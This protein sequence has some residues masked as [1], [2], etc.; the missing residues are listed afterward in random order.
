MQ[1]NED[2]HSQTVSF[3]KK[4]TSK[5][6]RY[7]A[8]LD[9]IYEQDGVSFFQSCCDLCFWQNGVLVDRK[10][11]SLSNDH[12]DVELQTTGDGKTVVALQ[13]VHMNVG[14]LVFSA[15]W[16][17]I[18]YMG[19]S[20]FIHLMLGSTSG[21][22]TVPIFTLLFNGFVVPAGLAMLWTGYKRHSAFIENGLEKLLVALQRFPAEINLKKEDYSAML[23]ALPVT[24]RGPGVFKSYAACVADV[25]IQSDTPMHKIGCESEG[26]LFR[27]SEWDVD[28]TYVPR[29]KDTLLLFRAM[30]DYP[31]GYLAGVFIA[32]WISWLY[33]LGYKFVINFGAG[34]VINNLAVSGFFAAFLL[35]LIT[36]FGIL[37]FQKA[38]NDRVVKQ[39][40]S[41]FKGQLESNEQGIF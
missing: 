19:I 20:F 8:T 3:T 29:N 40:M 13:S 22:S 26:F 37:F 35:M 39:A 38:R 14:Y 16:F 12:I 25:C 4:L 2:S 21:T 9:R 17:P 11:R 36:G 32:L 27:D 33:F 5:G 23:D 30:P 28:V 34:T 7:S 15:I 41:T 10:W 24:E 6:I 18:T 1:L 31:L